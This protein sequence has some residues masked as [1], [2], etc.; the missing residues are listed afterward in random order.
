MNKLVTTTPS[1]VLVNAYLTE[2]AKAY[3]ASWSAGSETETQESKEKVRENEHLNYIFSFLGYRQMSENNAEPQ[4]SCAATVPT[5][6]GDV[7]TSN[8][9]DN[10]IK[11]SPQ[12]VNEFEAL[13][14]RF[15]A[16][17]KR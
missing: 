14:E 3:G 4:E 11:A 5:E 1:S 16:L 9:S 7:D 2:I 10:V 6:S 8:K 15:A 12:L 17:K 13:A